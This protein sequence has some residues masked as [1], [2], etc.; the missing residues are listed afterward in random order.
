MAIQFTPEALQRI[1]YSTYNGVYNRRNPY[2]VDR[3]AMPFLSYASMHEDTAPLAG[4]DG[5]IVKYQVQSNLDLQGWERKDN[6]LFNEQSIE[7]EAQYPW[8]NIHQGI[9]FV[10]DDLE[11]MGFIILPNQ[12]R[13][14]S[15]A[16]PDSASDAYKLVNYVD[17]S[18]EAMMDKFDVNMDLLLHRDNSANPKLPQ[19]LDAYWPVG[20]AAGMTSDGDGTRGYYGE[21]SI[22]GK[23]RAS[24]P[25]VLQHYLWLGAT[26][27]AAGSLRTALTT[28]KREAQL[29]S[30]GR[31]K[32]GVKFIMA[33]AG[34]I[35]RYVKFATQNNT[36]F[37]Q[38]VTML[39]NGG[40]SRLD[41][42]IPDSGLHFEGTPI[43][44]NPTFEALDQLEGA[45]TYPWTRR[46]Y[47]IDPES[48]CV[49]Y[50]PGKKRYF[51]AP[52]DEG[53]VRVVRMSLDSKMVLLPKI[54]NAS[55]VVTVAA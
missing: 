13:G 24:W 4:A 21:G 5:P 38:A 42:G 12:P 2:K 1:A 33:G 55:T 32:S 44:H 35:D 51:S 31:S 17:R 50:A 52:L 20:V 18:I 37:T 46:A 43:I 10:H 34:F 53:S 3:K 41:I 40:L 6:L 8:S 54:L 16:K 9:E 47:L 14:K 29:R 48:M 30:R 49:A 36:N 15:F 7:L 11:A 22:G 27:G 19:G 28:A 25:D 39:S 26:Y 45:L 23:L